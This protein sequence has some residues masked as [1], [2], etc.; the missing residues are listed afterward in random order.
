M[1]PFPLT[2]VQSMHL[3]MFVSVPKKIFYVVHTALYLRCVGKARNFQP[4]LILIIVEVFY[5][6]PQNFQPQKYPFLFVY[7]LSL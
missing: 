3:V 6:P 2:F 1:L 7:G 4:L 5:N